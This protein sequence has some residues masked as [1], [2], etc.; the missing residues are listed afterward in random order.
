[1]IL[2]GKMWVCARIFPPPSFKSP[3]PC[4]Q[5]P[6]IIDRA[7]RIP[8]FFIFGERAR[9]WALRHETS[10]GTIPGLSSE[11]KNLDKE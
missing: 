10:G 3:H 5:K 7:K 6:N 11:L 8:F 9:E 2:P 4:L 1:M